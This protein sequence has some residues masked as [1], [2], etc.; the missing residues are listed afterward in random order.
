[1]AL[2]IVSG[3]LAL[4]LATAFQPTSLAGTA[5]SALGTLS[6]VVWL[7]TETPRDD[8]RCWIEVEQHWTCTGLSSS[9]HGIVVILGSERLAA[10]AVGVNPID[11][12]PAAWGRLV[13]V[14]PG[15]AD[16][17]DL[18]GL[19][20]VAR[21][22]ERS[23]SRPQTRRLTAIEDTTVRVAKVSETAFWVSGADV[24]PDA[25]L[26]L[27]GPAIGGQRLLTETLG[28]SPPD[29]VLLWPA[30]AASAIVGRVQGAHGEADRVDVQLWELLPSQGG[31]PRLDE[32]TPALRRRTMVT[33]DEGMFRFEGV[34]GGPFLLVAAHDTLGTARRWIRELGPFVD[35][36]LTPP[37]R[38]VGRVLR[39]GLPAPLASIRF[40]PDVD[41]FASSADPSD[42][43]ARDTRS[44]SDGRFVLPLPRRH[45]GVV[46]IVTDDGA[47]VR[48]KVQDGG[49]PEIQLGDVAIPDARHLTVRVLDAAACALVAVGPLDALGL[50]I[51]RATSGTGVYEID[52][53]EAGTWTLVADC[54]GTSRAIDPP[55]V[56]VPADRAAP[57]VD[58]R[59]TKSPG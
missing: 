7:S 10:V 34:A 23:P 44:V 21:R 18:R 58:A 31:L 41:A 36:E 45:A 49:P 27:D 30:A 53:P 8:V 42:F 28:E 14:T 59:V 20:L 13:R 17:D 12:T 56:V 51:V 32:D 3:P 9:A 29:E 4:A 19:V 47:A 6:R 24:D 52:L 16:P 39:R 54:G 2:S 38:V 57:P 26:A 43:I 40:I 22:P 50:S 37:G 11:P 55:I 15:G 25:F 1:M 33:D 35:L 46:Q 48:V 5:S